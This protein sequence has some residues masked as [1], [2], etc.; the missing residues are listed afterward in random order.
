VNDPRKARM[1]RELVGDE[2]EV[3]PGAG[4]S[5]RVVLI[6]VL[7]LFVMV[8]WEAWRMWR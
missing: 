8:F 6:V 2:H 3:M 7:V 1:L 5:V 4:Q